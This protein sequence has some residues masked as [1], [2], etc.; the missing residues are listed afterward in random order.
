MQELFEHIVHQTP[1]AVDRLYGYGDIPDRRSAPWSC[2]ALFQALSP[3]SKAIIMR[4]IFF[5]KPVE[6]RL[7]QSWM[8]ADGLPEL[9]RSLEVLAELRILVI[10]VVLEQEA[11]LVSINPYFRGSF[12]YALNN[13]EEPW[14]I[15]G[16]RVPN[17]EDEPPTAEELDEYSASSWEKVLYFLLSAD[18]ETSV[19]DSVKNFMFQT[20]IMQRRPEDP[21]Q[22]SITAKGYDYMLKDFHSQVWAFVMESLNRASQYQEEI[23][24]FIFMLSYCNLGSSYPVIALTKIQRLLLSEFC[25]LGIVYRN[26]PKAT[27]FYPCRIAI[28]MLCK[29]ASAEKHSSAIASS[30]NVPLNHRNISII[31]ETNFQVIAYL[32]N[33]LHLW[34]I[35]LFIDARTMVR[36]QN[37]VIGSIT[38]ESAKESFSIGIRASQIID[39]L[40]THAHPLAKKRQKQVP[41]NVA[42]QL[43]L[44]ELEKLRITVNDA[45]VID[46]KE[47][48]GGD[49][50]TVL[51]ENLWEQAKVL[52]VLL[53]SNAEKYM[54]AVTPSGHNQL[55]AYLDSCM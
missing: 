11:S 47:I 35:C 17:T 26:G 40:E 7:L 12:R 38:R 25:N 52:K 41:E 23:I 39:F 10:E 5:E 54:L 2:K 44:W 43:V 6:L 22:V 28:E 16:H 36:F 9:E 34:M 46:V 20:G 13:T 30:V 31:V 1:A 3:L 51:F 21:L 53:W 45:I 4:L 24:S 32:S 14:L 18:M 27:H 19:P 55:Q 42:D 49:R 37:M 8:S 48:A 29:S 33:D 15:G 50:L